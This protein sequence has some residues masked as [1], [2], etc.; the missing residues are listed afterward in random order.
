MLF[1]VGDH[2]NLPA[3]SHGGL[4]GDGQQVRIDL[5]SAGRPE[6]QISTTFPGFGRE[7][8]A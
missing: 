7:L 1:G 8:A 5:T 6:I 3:R 2:R 4:P